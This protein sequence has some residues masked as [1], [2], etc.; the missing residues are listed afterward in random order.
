MSGGS[1]RRCAAA[2]AA[3]VLCA[4]AVRAAIGAPRIVVGAKKF[5]EG[6]VLAE[7][8]AQVLE[9]Q[10]GATVE[11]RFNLAGT[12]VCFDGLRSG[13]LDLTPSTPAPVCATFSAIPPR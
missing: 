3:A 9:A 13:A 10:T 7:L 1:A 5:T 6:A 4:A 2:L 11:R 8:M 12:Q